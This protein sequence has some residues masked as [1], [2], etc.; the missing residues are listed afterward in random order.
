MNS[1][2]PGEGLASPQPG[3]HVLTRRTALAGVGGTVLGSVLLVACGSATAASAATTPKRGGTLRVGFTADPQNL[4]PH[5]LP[6]LTARTVGRAIADSLTEQ[7]PKTGKILPWLATS[8][9]ISSDVRTFT[10][11]LRKGVTFSDGTPFNAAVVKANW[12]RVLRIGPLARIAAG[13]LR[14]YQSSQVIDD[15]TVSITFSAPNAQF[16]QGTSESSLAMLSL[17]TLAK[18]PTAVA[19]GQVIGTGP[20]TLANYTLGQSITLA[21]RKDYRWASPIYKNRGRPY[22]DQ[23]AISFIPEASTFAGAVASGQIDY[24]YDVDS[25]VLQTI[26]SGGGTLQ[27][28]AMPAISIPIV[29]FVYR[30]VFKDART[31]RALSL[32][33]D[34]AQLVKSVFQGLYPASTA[35]LTKTNPGWADLSADLRYD[36]KGA[37][38]LLEQAGWTKVGS[39]GIRSNAAGE[40][41][42]PSIQYVSSETTT[43]SQQMFELLQQQWKKAGIDFVLQPVS[44]SSSA[45]L[46]QQPYDLDTWSQTRADADVLRTVYSSF[47]LNQSFLYG[48]PDP[49]LDDL[50]TQLQTTVNTAARLQVSKKA[51]Q[52]ILQQGYSVPLYDLIQYSAVGKGVQGATA[53]IEGKP[54]LTDYWLDSGRS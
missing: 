35:V 20:F 1:S 21:A 39:D 3:P 13:L 49:T 10:F 34:R 22:V 24:A 53:D 42:R 54:N 41:L 19:Q 6:Q 4:D 29:P 18:D 5:Q 36:L 44:V 8:W 14:G 27:K 52:R 38:S 9:K 7:D 15:Y 50:L 31:R 17:S 26:T 11:T 12:E 40:A 23:V 16:L 51:Q 37:I 43:T 33:T 2:A 47:Y 48:Y 28:T 46:N 25:S 45:N 30:P 32:A